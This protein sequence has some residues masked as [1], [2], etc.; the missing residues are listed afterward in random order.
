[1]V[2]VII[3]YDTDPIE[4]INLEDIVKKCAE[5]AFELENVTFDAE[6]S[7]TLTDNEGI[8]KINGEYRSIDKETDVLSFPQFD[9]ETPSQ[10]NEDE[11][12]LDEGAVMLGDIVLSK[13]K[14]YE[15]A[16]EYGHGALRETAYLTVHSLMH[17]LGYDHME[18]GEKAVMRRHEEAV[19]EAL[20]Y[21][22]ENESK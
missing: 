1:M 7:V 18:D 9:F 4:E 12:F 15:Q 2:S 6:I 19:L 16:E 20:G 11:L 13:D 21:T 10:F 22:R 14:I 8:R 17:L 3:E 5:K